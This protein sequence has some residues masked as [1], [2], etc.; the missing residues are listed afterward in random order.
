MRV[1]VTGGAGYIGTELVAQLAGVEDVQ[2]V[3]VYDNLSRGNYNLFLDYPFKQSGKVKLIAGDI[4][5]TR[6]LNQVMDGVD[7]VYHLAANVT[8]PFANTD[9]HFFEQVNHWGTAEVTYAAEKSNVKRIIYTSSTSVYGSSEEMVD[10][11]AETAPRTFYGIS[12]LRAERQLNTLQDKMEIYIIRCGNVYGYSHSM[13]FD[14]VINKFAFEANF[15]NRIS[16]QGDGRQTRAFIHIDS[17]SQIL[18][19]LVDN[20]VPVGKYNLVEE[21]YQIIDIVDALKQIK[22]DLEFIFV[23][24]HLN[25]RTMKVSTDLLLKKFLELPSQRPLNEQL[26][27]FMNHFSF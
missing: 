15:H 4:L 2:E 11:S 25:L 17:V 6:M 23:D 20:S 16:I 9:P 27:Q 5:D 19:N 24:Q 12:K 26:Q 14:A 10:E 8:T 3:I 1:L 21:N 7:I 22:P 13:R 18:V